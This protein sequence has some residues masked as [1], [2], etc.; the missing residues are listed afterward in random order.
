LAAILLS[1]AVTCLAA[2]FLGQA[3]LRLAGAGE[4][5]WLAPAV[6][7]SV[8]MLIAAPAAD[9]PGHSTTVAILLGVLTIAAAVWCLRSPEHRPPLSGLLA[10]APVGL[11]VLVPFL[12]AGRGGI[13]G[14]SLNNDMSAHLLIVEALLSSSVTEVYP[15]P[16]DYPIGPHGI[17]AVLNKAF[18]IDVDHAF[19]GW[20]LAIPLI[21]AWT[22]LAV[23]RRASWFGK[24]VL[25]TVAGLPFLVAAY[26][27]EGAFKEVVQA[28]L[29]MAVVL[30]LSGCGPRLGRGR[31]VPF[32]L[33]LG[34][35]VSVYSIAGLPWPLAIAG[36]WLVGLLAA[37]AWRRQLREVPRV[38]RRELPALGIGLA[39]LVIALLPQVHRMWE[40]LALRDGTGISPDELGNLVTPLPGWEAFG[41]WNS[42]DFR[43]PASPAFTGGMW[44]AF[45]LALVLFGTYWAFRRGRW[46][47][48]LAAGAALVIWKVSDHSQSPYVSA[49]ALVIASPL[50]L[51]LAVLPLVDRE[52]GRR[53]P[54]PWLLAPLLGLVLLLRV[55]SDDMR[56]LRWSPVGPADHAH[57]LESFR[58][59]LVGEPTLFLGD[60]DFV[61]WE[62]AGV[63][64]S[65]PVNHAT[66]FLPMRSRKSW[67]YGE[68]LDV[69][70]VD[71]GTLNE[72]GWVITTRGRSGSAM[73]PQL[74]RVR[75]T[76]SFVLW[77]RV[78]PVPERSILAEGDEPGKI[79]DCTSDEGAA[80]LSGGGVAAVRERPVVVAGTSL[81][82]GATG[83]VGI[84]LSRGAWDLQA[85]YTSSYPVDVTAP[86]LRAVLPANLDRPGPRW[87][88]GRIATDGG[89]EEL[90][91]RVGDAPLSQAP[92]G[93][94]IVSVIATK[95]SPVR[96]VPI[97]QACGKYVDWYRNAAPAQ[98]R[99][100]Q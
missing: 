7:L 82:A 59:L 80:A 63:P 47:L 26:Y 69:D 33:L 62:L 98:S 1:G 54:G 68:P 78:A 20:T 38:V 19:S 29:V 72:Y 60:D 97:R 46:L 8:T 76:D 5:N 43:L 91:F 24:A 55:G 4:W 34:G 10:A 74:R 95:V 75:T 96:V 79:L 73:P 66:V 30:N 15:L 85:D 13:L 3:A 77:R 86:G 6:G 23:A 58:P 92:T 88:I 28:G 27:G 11:L 25:A 12:A 71:T 21:N 57:Q 67:E 32:A 36:I 99:R 53:S 16:S 83:S 22:V 40:F 56:A 14:V 89:K 50:L 65:A 87:P 42:P 61:E 94:S 9:V 64:V 93:A 84:G 41:V 70:S 18:G 49:K 100:R 51:L 45:V 17:A 39:V 37:Q 31:W 44:T 35:I 48:P 52:P 90:T 81:P 2:L